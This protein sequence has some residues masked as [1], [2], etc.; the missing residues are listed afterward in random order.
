MNV[1][2]TSL[3]TTGTSHASSDAPGAERASS[4]EVSA[5]KRMPS[6]NGGGGP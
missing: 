6:G 2:P 3:P 5:M 4:E 1:G